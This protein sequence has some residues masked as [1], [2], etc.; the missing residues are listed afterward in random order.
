MLRA[1]VAQLNARLAPGAR[2]L[3]VDNRYVDGSSSPIDHVDLDGD[4]FQ[5]RRIADGKTLPVL[6]NFLDET[7]LRSCVEGLA[8]DVGYRAFRHY[9]ALRY[10]V[11]RQ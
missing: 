9:W 4:T 7:E 11:P 2:V 5:Q 3:F 1:F 6:K 8:A 10:A